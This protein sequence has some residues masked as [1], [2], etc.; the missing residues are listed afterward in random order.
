[1]NDK[2]EHVRAELA[3]PTPA[4]HGCH[5]PG[6]TADVPPATWGCRRHWAMLPGLIRAGIWATYRPG[7]ETTKT[8]SRDYVKAARAAQDWIAKNG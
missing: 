2:V 3:K 1:M 4:G 8:P 7:Q 6:C 5:W